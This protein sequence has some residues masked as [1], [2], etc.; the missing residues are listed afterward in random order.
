MLMW[1]AGRTA[2]TYTRTHL[3]CPWSASAHRA[4]TQE[5]RGRS[6]FRQLSLIFIESFLCS[7]TSRKLPLSEG[8]LERVRI[9]S[10]KERVSLSWV[11]TW[12]DLHAD[13]NFPRS[14]LVGVE[15]S[16]RCTSVTFDLS[17]RFSSDSWALIYCNMEAIQFWWALKV[18]R[19]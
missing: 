12:R 11:A 4:V 16:N 18:K 13:N 19:C 7:R 1:Q 6:A 15:P 5:R 8:G 14:A 3:S 9:H 17:R 2:V 10:E